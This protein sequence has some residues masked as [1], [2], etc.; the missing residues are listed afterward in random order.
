MLITSNDNP[1]VKEWQKLSE[2]KYREK[3]NEFLVEGMHLVLEACKTD[4]IKELILE[5]DEILSL[6]VPTTYV[7]N[8]VIHKISTLESPQ[9]VMAVCKIKEENNNIGTKILILDSIQDPGNLGMIIRSAVAF[10]IDTIVLGTN[11][12]DCYNPKVVRA[13]QGMLFHTNIIRRDLKEFIPELK[14]K[15]IKVYGTRVTHGTNLK[16]VNIKDN[17]AIIMGNEGNGVDD[18]ILDLC[19]DYL[20]I[21]MNAVCESLNVGVAT[22]IILYQFSE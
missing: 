22:S 20:Y 3:N 12:V 2:R 6:D 19:D 16:E 4:Y 14:N 17:Y 18:D 8:N 9:N 13:T 21:N 15:G 5:Q 7:T 11:T 10:K 1:K